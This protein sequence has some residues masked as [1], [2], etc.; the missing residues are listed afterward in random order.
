MIAGPQ[1]KSWWRWLLGFTAVRVIDDLVQ[2]GYTKQ[3]GLHYMI[4]AS[5]WEWRWKPFRVTRNLRYLRKI[6]RK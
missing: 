1:P 4:K 5:H 2:Q 3:G 6:R